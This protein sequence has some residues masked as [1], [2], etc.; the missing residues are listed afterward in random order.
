MDFLTAVD[1]LVTVHN[2][3]LY[4]IGANSM[5][6]KFLTIFPLIFSNKFQVKDFFK[7]N[8]QFSVCFFIDNVRSIVSLGDC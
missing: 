8:V 2:C 7:I 1:V 3:V 6:V 5:N 4:I